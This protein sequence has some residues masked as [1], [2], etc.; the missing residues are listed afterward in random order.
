MFGLDHLVR[1]NGTIPRPSRHLVAK[2]SPVVA[3]KLDQVLR[4]L[5]GMEE[6]VPNPNRLQQ[7]I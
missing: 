2:D 6:L 5:T 1:T 7:P 3:V 4:R